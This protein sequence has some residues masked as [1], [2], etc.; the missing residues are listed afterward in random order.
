[1]TAKQIFEVMLEDP[2]L[3][4]KYGLTTENLKKMNLHQ[5]SKEGIIEL[6]KLVVNGVENGTPDRTINSQIKTHFNL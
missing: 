2:L 4:E 3:R 1:M 5:D 6:I